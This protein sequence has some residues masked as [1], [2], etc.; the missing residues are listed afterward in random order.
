MDYVEEISPFTTGREGRKRGKKN[1]D[2]G[3]KRRG[4]TAY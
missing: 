2:N 3:C 4:K 1:G